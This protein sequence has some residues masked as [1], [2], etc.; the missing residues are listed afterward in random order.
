M[1]EQPV[2]PA[3]TPIT[4]LSDDDLAR[5]SDELPALMAVWDEAR[6]ELDERQVE[7][8][9]DRLNR[10]WAIET[11][12]IE[13]IYT[14]DEGTTRLLIE[15]GIDASLIAHD[16]SDGGSPELIAGIIRDHQ[17]AVEW[18]FE[19]VR[20]QR[21]LTTSFIKELHHLMTRKQKHADG[22]DMFGRA[23][24]IELRHGEYKQ[25]PNNPTRSD[26]ATHEYCPPEHVA[27]EMDRLI[28]FHNEHTVLEVPPDLEAAWLHHRFIQIHPFQDG[29]GR[30]ARAIASL[31][32]LR[33]G[34]FPLVV[35]A[36]ERS[37]YINTLEAADTG[38]IGPLT[39]LVGTIQKRAWRAALSI[40]GEVE[41]EEARLEQMIDAIGE[42]FD[43]HDRELRVETA[44]AKEIANHLQQIAI[45]KFEEVCD[46][47]RSRI[48]REAADRDF[49]VIG[50]RDED[51]ERRT[52][53]RHQVVHTARQLDYFANL[54]DYHAWARLTFKTESGQS[55]ILLSFHTVGRD[56]RGVVGASMCFYRRQA[57]GDEDAARQV[58]ELQA[59]SEDLFQVNYKED[60][61]EAERR[62]APWL[63]RALVEALDQWRRGE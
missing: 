4:D 39:E 22:V 60:L 35:R 42:A 50:G 7:E 2:D 28:E 18:L 51:P 47:L 57:S 43:S 24:R 53:C 58:V 56:F 55:D 19:I 6:G 40:L 29:N 36:K 15:Q 14:L 62:F 11:G 10:E 61:E 30:A 5:A 12:I 45:D 31:V 23:T 16:D 27:A 38:D 46:G 1:T 13:R 17:E 52:W 20:Q 44:Q 41:R 25:R 37:N 34:W 32:L 63:E 3:W 33:A 49:F 59:V 21:P 48:G 26:G 8:F 9:N 54:R